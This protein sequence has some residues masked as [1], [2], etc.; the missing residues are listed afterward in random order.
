MVSKALA[1]MELSDS[2]RRVRALASGSAASLF[3]VALI[4]MALRNWSLNAEGRELADLYTWSSDTPLQQTFSLMSTEP[5]VLREG[6]E[7]VRVKIG[8]ALRDDADDTLRTLDVPVLLDF[9]CSALSDQEVFDVVERVGRLVDV[10]AVEQPFD[11]GNW[12]DHASLKSKLPC[13][14]SLDEGVKSLRDLQSIVRYGAGEMVC[15]KPSRVGG[16]A[17]AKS[18]VDFAHENGLRPYIGGF[19]ESA[20]AREQLRVLANH[21]VTEPSDIGPVN[22]APSPLLGTSDEVLIEHLCGPAREPA[23]VAEFV[24]ELP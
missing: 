1:G 21:C 13:A 6:V 17:S 23:L 8:G 5:W 18:L 22:F 2:W 24:V 10:A 9:N 11:A 20:F 7:R 15:I 19:F 3:A 4:E 12:I 14:L 16:F